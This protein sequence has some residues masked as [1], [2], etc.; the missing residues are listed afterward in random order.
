M[1]KKRGHESSQCPC[2][3]MRQCGVGE[4]IGATLSTSDADDVDDDDDVMTETRRRRRFWRLD[5]LVGAEDEERDAD[6]D[7]K[8]DADSDADS[9]GVSGI[10]PCGV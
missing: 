5:A 9:D 1:V 6:S 7:A 8:L 2:L 4:D 10:P 3:H